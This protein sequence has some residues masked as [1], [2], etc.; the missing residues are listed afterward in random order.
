MK[1]AAALVGLLWLGLLGAHALGASAQLPI[2]TTVSVPSVSVPTVPI[3]TVPTPTLP[4]PTLPAPQPPN[5][6]SPVPAPAPGQATSGVGTITSAVAGSATVGTA[7]SLGGGSSSSPSRDSASS[8]GASRSSDSSN[9]QSRQ[10]SLK[11][12]QSSRHWIA[13]SGPKKRRITTL[14]FSLR[15]AARV[16]FI[17]KQVFPVCR[18]IG[19]FSV[20]GHAGVNRVRF[21]GRVGRE[22]LGPGTYR[23]SARTRG[24]QFVQ[25]LILVV[26]DGGAPS[27]EEFAAVRASNVCSATRG[28]S[29]AAGVSTG[30]IASNLAAVGHIQRP[31]GQPSVGKGPSGDRGG[32]LG[33]TVEKTARAVRPLLVALL[34]L[35]ILLLGLAS[36]PAVAIADPRLNDMLTRHRPQIAGVGAAA[37]V[38]TAIAFL[39][40]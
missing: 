13:T 25:R 3:P 20:R 40:G 38:A 17:V 28:I 9:A 18:T 23:I 33:S 4:T 34:G 39:I 6:T 35:S 16:I 14:T 32:V 19:R 21:A 24:G 12:F 11:H 27:R 37:L 29:S 8:A 15:R 10:A 5:V 30:T 36:L 1:A 31:Q 26:V 22:Q 2:T 7:S